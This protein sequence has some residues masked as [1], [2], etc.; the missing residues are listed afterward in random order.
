MSW[1]SALGAGAVGAVGG[2]LIGGP[3][4]AMAGFG[5]GIGAAA[6]GMSGAPG[7]FGAMG[8]AAAGGL[9]GFAVGGPIGM[10][11]GGGLGALFGNAVQGSFQQPPQMPGYAPYFPG[12]GWGGNMGMPPFG[13]GMP[14]FGMGFPQ[15]GFGYPNP[16]QFG[17]G[18]YGGCFPPPPPQ[19]VCYPPSQQPPQT[20]Q[21]G[22]LKQGGPGQPIDYTTHGGYK[23]NV[24]GTTVTITDP[25]GKHTVTHSGDPHEYVDGKHVK[26][27]DEKTRTMILEDGTRVTMNATSKDGL[28]TDTTIY[29]GAQEIKI[30]N[31]NTTVS[32]VS[33][34]PYK[35][36][37]DAR[38]Q[39]AGETAYFGHDQR[40]ALV[41][42]DLFKQN[43][44]LSVTPYNKDISVLERPHNHHHH[45]RHWFPEAVAV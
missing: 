12:G 27:W 6:A 44:D 32:S 29:D 2:F 34:D 5:I 36:Q 13:M 28:I 8:G 15:T 38:H 10:L 18:N 39:A 22:E 35:T 14:P 19:C 17:F 43:A 1:L 7:G 40:G 21:G 16:S 30:N 37:Y 26:D 25:S 3:I 20:H 42:R 41:Y 4:G 11:L 24:N 45:R 9:V 31:Q 33:F 23:V